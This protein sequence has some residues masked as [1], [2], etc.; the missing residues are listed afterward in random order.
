MNTHKQGWNIIIFLV[1]MTIVVVLA[2]NSFKI[3]SHLL[4]SSRS[5]C[6]YHQEARLLEGLITYGIQ[7]CSENKKQLIS[8][9]LQEP[10]TM[11][12]HFDTWPSEETQQLF[13]LH[14]GD[15]NILSDRGV[16][17]LNAHLYK[18]KIASLSGGCELMARD[19]KNL[20]GA[21]R[22]VHWHIDSIVPQ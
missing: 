21:M 22:I 13:G 11:F 2:T 4:V 8:W 3:A 5:R 7:L 16:L 12:V 1:I 14:A 9:G 17:Y 19:P 10:Q 18:N 20:Q 6:H 15:L